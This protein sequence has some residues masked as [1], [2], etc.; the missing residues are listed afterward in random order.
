MDIKIKLNLIDKHKIFTIKAKYFPDQRIAIAKRG[1]RQKFSA[2][3][4]VDPD[5]IYHVKKGRRFEYVAYVDVATCQS[6]SIHANLPLD[7]EVKNKLDYLIEEK[8]WKSLIQ[9]SKLP[10]S[11]ILIT[12]FAGCGLFYVIKEIILPIFGI[13]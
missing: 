11:T 8:F 1:L 10:L 13:K 6:K 2:K 12:L 5:H 4:V 7:G 3:Y 9:Q